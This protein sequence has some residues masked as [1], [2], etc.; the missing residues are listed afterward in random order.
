MESF[1]NQ[2]RFLRFFIVLYSPGLRGRKQV[3]HLARSVQARYKQ[4]RMLGWNARII[5]TPLLK[6]HYYPAVKRGTFSLATFCWW[7]VLV[8]LLAANV[9]CNKVCFMAYARHGACIIVYVNRI[10]LAL[11]AFNAGRLHWHWLPAT[12]SLLLLSKILV[13][14]KWVTQS[15][16]HDREESNGFLFQWVDCRV[17]FPRHLGSPTI[18]CSITTIWKNDWLKAS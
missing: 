1:E 4:P 5:R 6:S 16:A 9:S 3:R 15:I 14:R 13:R 18:V 8:D 17:L 11:W 12:E 10:A 7:T 2:N